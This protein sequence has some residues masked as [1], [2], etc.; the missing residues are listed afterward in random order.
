MTPAFRQYLINELIHGIGSIG[1][2][3][4]AFGQRLV[5]FVV[6]VPMK[7]RGLNSEGQPVGHAVD[8]VSEAGDVVAEY[9]AE[10]DY[11]NR[12]YSKIRKDWRHAVALHPQVRR[13]LLISGREAGP[14]AMT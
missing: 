1:Q 8:S 6:D 11:F 2:H 10:K 14:K 13:I 12:P 7:H 4:E 9:S 5:D 3:F